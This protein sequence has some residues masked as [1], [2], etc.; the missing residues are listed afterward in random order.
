MATL[1]PTRPGTPPT[2]PALGGLRRH[3]AWVIAA[4]LAILALLYA[5]FFNPASRPG[6]DADAA[7]QRM[8][9]P[10]R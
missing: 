5:F 1:K 3:I 8:N 4:K 6:I 7:G 10:S 2:P 9:I